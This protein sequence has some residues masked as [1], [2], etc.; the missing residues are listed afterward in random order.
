MVDPSWPEFSVIVICHNEIE[1]LR[2]T[3]PINLNSLRVGTSRTFDVILLIDGAESA[4]VGELIELAHSNGVDEVRLRRRVRNC[5]TGDPSNNGHIQAFSDRT[6]FLLSL[7]S[8]VALFRIDP[9]FDILDACAQFF[10]RHPGRPLIHRMD[11]HDEW[12]WKLERS[13][14]DI[15]P[16]VWSVNRLAS[17]FLVYDTQA[18]R[19]HLPSP[20]LGAYHDS[21]DR[22]HNFEDDLSLRLAEPQGPGIAAPFGWP[23]RVYHCDRKIAA[24]SVHY[25]KST[26][27]KLQRLYQREA[28]VRRLTADFVLNR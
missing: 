11:D 23:I 25:S 7:E 5:A 17:H 27:E 14:P 13:G 6:R 20:N 9:S 26:A 19:K 4:P 1:L 21:P 8:D 22:W 2:R 24:G 3:L 18:A 12:V 28:E 10:E 15:E 16:G